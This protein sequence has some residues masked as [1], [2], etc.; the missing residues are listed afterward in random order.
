ME[1]DELLEVFEDPDKQVETAPGR[2]ESL[3]YLLT[4]WDKTSLHALQAALLPAGASLREF[5]RFRRIK[6]AFDLLRKARIPA[7][8][9][10]ACADSNPD[11][12]EV[13]SAKQALRARYDEAS[14]RQ[15]VK[16]Y[17]DRL[18]QSR[19]DALVGYVIYKTKPSLN[20]V[21]VETPEQLYELLLIDPEM[22]TCMETSR[23][24]QAIS[25]V[26]LY[27]QRCLLNL[28]PVAPTSAP[29]RPLEMDEALPGVGSQP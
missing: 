14:W 18:R 26:Q 23:I 6:T 3:L 1:G 15:A 12:R 4:G 21:P 20:G 8:R 11:P 13:R 27:V 29:G 24:R 9:L 25:T 19:R 17:H 16:P 28:E 2:Y 7:T 22:E 5:S 10:L